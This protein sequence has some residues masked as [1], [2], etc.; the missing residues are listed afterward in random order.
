MFLKTLFGLKCQNNPNH[1]GTTPPSSAGI[2]QQSKSETMTTEEIKNKCRIQF[3][4]WLK[5]AELTDGEAGLVMISQT[6]AEI[7]EKEMGR[8]KALM[9]QQNAANN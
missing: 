2:N 9:Q 7:A 8:I 5:G 4:C 3:E 6:L 1:P